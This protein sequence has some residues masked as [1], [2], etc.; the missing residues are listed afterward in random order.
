MRTRNLTAFAAAALV[1]G[2]LTSAAA[3]VWR[4]KPFD[5]AEH[6]GL[7]PLCTGCHEGIPA[8][9]EEA[10][11]PPQ[12]VCA[13]C[14]DGETEERVAWSGP[15]RSP[16]NVV[17]DH[18]AHAAELEEHG[19]P[20]AECESCHADPSADVRMSVDEHEEL[21]TCFGCHEHEAEDHYVDA[22]CAVCH[23]TLA[24][25][26]FDR[27]RIEGL[28]EPADHEAE[29]FL[30]EEH[31]TLAESDEGRCATCH[32]V[33]RC[34]AC[35]VDPR[36]PA[37]ESLPSAPPHMDLPPFEA[38]Y[39]EPDSHTDEGWLASHGRQARVQDCATC[40]TSNDC[41]AC[42]Q[43]PLPDLAAGLVS[44]EESAAPG[45]VVDRHPPESHESLF[46]M[47]AH[48]TLAA[49]DEG[50]CTTCHTEA[51]CVACHD[52]APGQGGYHPPGF[53]MRHAADAFGQDQECATCHN[54]AAFCR[55][56]HTQAGLGSDGRLGPGYHDA[57]PLWLLRHG[58]A[59]RQN[60]E[61]CAS[62]HEQND[63]TQCHS[64]LGSFQVSPHGPDFDA[65]RAWE[66]NPRSC[67]ACHV[68]NP[69]GGTVP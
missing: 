31:G 42:H 59:A 43:E 56:C 24:A 10:F 14:H 34:A 48:A 15:S 20:P 19:D 53:V 66:R 26:G 49:S 44:R 67:I 35:H 62:C 33:E 40:H 7:F 21:E 57:E 55:A 58:Q 50:V 63:C 16:S 5:H 27:R 45:V 61:S 54:S 39:P 38:H 17:F 29:V 36:R 12:D 2:T 25:S 4:E 18:Q 69:I 1:L 60:L 52:G 6:E 8:G 37:I 23:E 47:E 32:T 3:G 30:A 13:R 68:K 11:Y 46:F 28:P 65:R 51:T 64:V 9:D 22:D 41:A